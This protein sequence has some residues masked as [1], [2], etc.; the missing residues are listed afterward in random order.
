LIVREGARIPKVC[1]KCGATKDV[2]RREIPFAV[3]N[4]AAGAGMLVIGVGAE[5]MVLIGLGLLVLFA[6]LAFAFATG[7]RKAW[8]TARWARDEQVALPV[9]AETAKKVVERA[10]RRAARKQREAAAP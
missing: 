4:T 2:S 9:G 8:V 5:A 10:E 7:M 3:G 6:A 1:V